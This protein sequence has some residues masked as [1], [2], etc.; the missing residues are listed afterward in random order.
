MK[1]GE[2]TYG[3]LIQENPDNSV[4]DSPGGPLKQM[5]EIPLKT[6]KKPR[7]SASCLS[8][9]TEHG[10]RRGDPGGPPR[11]PTQRSPRAGSASLEG[12]HLPRAGSAPFEGVRL[13]RA[14]ST[15]L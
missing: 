1:V 4:G 13:P 3:A 5:G 2:G 8:A 14:D 12:A 11:R 7:V 9:H 6:C 10:P 15:S